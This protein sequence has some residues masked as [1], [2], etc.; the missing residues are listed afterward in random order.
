MI[1]Y[2]VYEASGAQSG[3]HARVI[4]SGTV[5]E[6]E[7]A[8]RIS[9]GSTFSPA[10]VL[11]IVECVGQ[12]IVR[13]LKD[14]KSVHISGLGYFNLRI[15]GDI[16]TKAG[17]AEM[18]KNAAVSNIHFRPE[19]NI[20]NQFQNVQIRREKR[21]GRSVSSL[22]DEDICQAATL[23]TEQ[24]GMFTAAQLENALK[25]RKNMGYA[26]IRR[27]VKEGRVERVLFSS[28]QKFYR[29]LPV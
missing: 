2:D 10:E 9:S 13:A 8:Y 7:M 12:E 22:S 29:T 19:Q 6:R 25:L 24:N 15:K 21:I 16:V 1:K 4:E 27:L 20:L 18:L 3:K 17:G 23:L 28:H 26:I 11:P 14:G 5:T